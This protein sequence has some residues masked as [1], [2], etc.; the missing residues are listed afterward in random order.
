MAMLTTMLTNGHAM[1]HDHGFMPHMGGINMRSVRSVA[2]MCDV[3]IKC[4]LKA[5]A[6]SSGNVDEAIVHI[7]Q[8]SQFF[9]P[10]IPD[11]I[12]STSRKRPKKKRTLAGSRSSRWQ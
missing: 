11:I 7:I 12:Y 8:V 5:L 1:G 6:A 4:A 9:K 2:V 3:G 10:L